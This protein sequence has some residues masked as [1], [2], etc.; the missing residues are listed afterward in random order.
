MAS[1][2]DII[3]LK[4]I[5]T[6]MS[7]M[8]GGRLVLFSIA[9]FLLSANQEGGVL[10]RCFQIAFLGGRRAGWWGMTRRFSMFAIYSLLITLTCDPC[11][12]KIP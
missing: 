9:A 12:R 3:D 2:V 4:S 6:T 10:C 7:L 8:V 11:H 5:P 1:G